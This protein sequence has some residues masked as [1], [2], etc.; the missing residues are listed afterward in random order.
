MNALYLVTFGQLPGEDVL[1]TT[2]AYEE[3]TKRGSGRHDGQGVA[4][5]WLPE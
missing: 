1:T 4:L 5:L 2:I 3:D